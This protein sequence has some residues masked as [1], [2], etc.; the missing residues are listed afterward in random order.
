MAGSMAGPTARSVLSRSAPTD[1]PVDPADD[2]GQHVI[3]R[4]LGQLLHEPLD[5]DR[6]AVAGGPDRLHEADQV[7][8]SG[9]VGPAPVQVLL[10]DE[11]AGVACTD[12]V[13]RDDVRVA[14]PVE[15][16]RDSA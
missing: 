10:R 6:P 16:F 13:D 4:L 5:L 1:G 3:D 7:Y 14:H 15:V 2:V 12:D 11:L 8:H 9:V